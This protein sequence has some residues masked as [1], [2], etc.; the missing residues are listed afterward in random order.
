MVSVKIREG[1]ELAEWLAA[2]VGKAH[3]NLVSC[4]G[5]QE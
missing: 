4:P 1:C 5:E 2:S 3:S